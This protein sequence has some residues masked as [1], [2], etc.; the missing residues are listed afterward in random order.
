MEYIWGYP[1]YRPLLYHK[2]VNT[3]IYDAGLLSTLFY[4]SVLICHA[5]FMLAPVDIHL[6]LVHVANSC[7]KPTPKRTECTEAWTKCPLFWIQEY[8]LSTKVCLILLVGGITAASGRCNNMQ[9]QGIHAHLFIYIWYHMRCYTQYIDLC[10]YF[11]MGSWFHVLLM[12]S[13]NVFFFLFFSF[14]QCIVSNILLKF[15]WIYTG[16]SALGQVEACHQK[17]TRHHLK[18]CRTTD[19]YMRQRASFG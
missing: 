2:Y 9:G 1:V 13:A 10:L 11:C 6:S 14:K 3:T 4:S 17:A 5:Y 15:C 16:R 18:Q 8:I 19:A 7:A 12:I